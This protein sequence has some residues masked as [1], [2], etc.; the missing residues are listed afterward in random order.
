MPLK[1]FIYYLTYLLS[2]SFHFTFGN[3]MILFSILSII[4]KNN[5]SQLYFYFLGSPSCSQILTFKKHYYKTFQ[6]LIFRI[7]P[8]TYVLSKTAVIILPV[9]HCVVHL[10][11]QGGI[12]FINK[13]VA[14]QPSSQH[15]NPH[16]ARTGSN[17][18]ICS[19]HTLLSL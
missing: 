1:I 8:Y 16:A 5:L 15:S 17:K 14:S 18:K 9:Q 13:I 10:L 12:M 11:Y 2:A 4:F 7:M 6:S 19:S 3:S